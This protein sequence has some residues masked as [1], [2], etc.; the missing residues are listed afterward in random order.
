VVE[1]LEEIVT[2]LRQSRT[3]RRTSLNIPDQPRQFRWGA[4]IAANG[5]AWR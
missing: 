4:P 1:I 2:A 3:L 5:V